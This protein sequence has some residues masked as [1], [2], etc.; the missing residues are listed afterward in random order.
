MSPLTQMRRSGWVRMCHV[1]LRMRAFEHVFRDLALAMRSLRRAPAF[2][3]TVI[4]TI[5]IGMGAIAAVL[6]IVDLA[7][8]RRYPVP[9]PERL[10]FVR[11]IDSRPS[12]ANSWGSFRDWRD[13]RAGIQ[14]M[15]SL[16]AYSLSEFKLGGE[17]AGTEANGAFVSAN[18]FAALGVK[19]ARGRYLSADE[20][21]PQGAHAVVVVS[22]AFW[23]GVLAGDD[24]AVGKRIVIGAGEFMIVGIAPRGFTGL[25]P[26]GRTD[27]WLPYTMQE[28]ATGA[29]FLYSERDARRA[30]IFGK[31]APGASLAQVQGSLDRLGPM[32]AASAPATN[33]TV[34]F[35]AIKRDRMVSLTEAPQALMM[36]ALALAMIALVHLIAC[37]NVASLLI[38]RGAA[39]RRELGV[40][41]CLGA[42]RGRVMMQSLAEPIL[43]GLGGAVGAVFVAR[44][45]NRGI[46]S[47][48][49]L[50][51]L[52]PQIDLRLLA[53]VLGVAAI[54]VAK[55]GMMPAV[56]AART[57][58]IEVV[59]GGGGGIRGGRS[60]ATALVIGGQVAMAVLMLAQATILIG[61]FRRENAADPG[62][63]WR[64]MIVGQVERR[65]FHV[66]SDEFAH[67]LE[68][69]VERA[70][71]VPGVRRVGAA[72]T[73]PLQLRL[74]DDITPQGTSL[75]NAER[76]LPIQMV[77]TGYFAA[78][79]ARVVEGREFGAADRTTLAPPYY[80]DIAVVNETFARRYWPGR[81]AIGQT[82]VFRKKPARIVGVVADLN[83]VRMSGSGP[84]VYFP[85]RQWLVTEFSIITMVT[86]G[87]DPGVVAS[88]LHDVLAALPAVKTPRVR[89][90]EVIR[91][92]M[93]TMSRV[94]AIVL[95]I[96]AGVALLLTA[97]G[98]YGAV[99]MWAATRRRE[100]GIRIALG[101]R[102]ADLYRLLMTDAGR[103][104]AIGAA[105]GAFGSVLLVRVERA[106]YGPSMALDPVPVVASLCVL[107]LV[108][109][110]AVVLP[111]RKA[112]KLQ[113]T[114]V[115]RPD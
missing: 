29:T 101:A 10:V 38:A 97:V 85:M 47:M 12:K 18:Y 56:V 80:F 78:I 42:S 96:A 15:E 62:F 5:A 24:R 9:E 2:A 91:D 113:P 74:Y 43:L 25:H 34:S 70:A 63:D 11:T 27:L 26:E 64:H 98:L 90:M 92:D 73:A 106:S 76:A 1:L 32:L 110:V 19:P 67:T 112:M 100:L 55:F 35:R 39:R 41:I 107:A 72:A 102:A 37:G 71:T 84:K 6:G 109:T 52:E 95:S 103:V 33:E 57:D 31:L 69:A 75:D 3:L 79:G 59:Q 22:D 40:R 66:R 82:I 48:W 45:V 44:A 86:P 83:D 23:Q 94:L 4:A 17:L 8:L 93:A 88:H 65:G 49:F 61:K 36:F 7:Y 28:L 21:E 111:A 54:T 14:G 16:A 50:S 20:E 51:A 105:L 114:E 60:M 53:I 89:T 30:Q 46:A 68:L 115:M 58:P 99:A 87:F 13:L 77:G 108:M 104:A 81:S